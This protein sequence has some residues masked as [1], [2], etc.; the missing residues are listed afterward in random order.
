VNQPQNQ[1][2]PVEDAFPV[3]RQRCSELFD[4]NLLLRSHVASLQR[5]LRDLGQQSLAQEPLAAGPEA[6]QPSFLDDSE[7]G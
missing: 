5:Q 6:A 3:Y 1:Q 4:E 2:I 7:R